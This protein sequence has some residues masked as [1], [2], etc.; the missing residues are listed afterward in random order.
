MGYIVT[1]LRG[2]ENTVIPSSLLSSIILYFIISFFI[3]TLYILL[4]IFMSLFFIRDFKHKTK[5]GIVLIYFSDHE[6][7]HSHSFFYENVMISFFFMAE[8][9]CTYILHFLYLLMQWRTLRPIWIVWTVMW[10]KCPYSMLTLSPLGINPE[11]RNS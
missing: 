8:F 2:L 4:F 10:C 6:T 9:N 1:F 5:D 11:V 7:L 3:Y